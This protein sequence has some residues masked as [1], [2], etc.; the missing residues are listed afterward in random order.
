[1]GGCKL[2]DGFLPSD[3]PCLVLPRE[4]KPVLERALPLQGNGASD[5]SGLTQPGSYRF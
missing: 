4:A 3:V 5:S 1:M 2:V